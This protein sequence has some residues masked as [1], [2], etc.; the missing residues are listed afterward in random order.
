[1]NTLENRCPDCLYLELEGKAVGNQGLLSSLPQSLSLKKGKSNLPN[2]ID[3]HLTIN[4]NEQW[5]DMRVGRIKF[6]LSGG[7]LRLNLK[8]GEIPYN[9]RKLNSE[10]QLEI[11]KERQ[12]QASQ[13]SKQGTEGSLEANINPLR[14]VKVVMKGILERKASAGRTDKFQFTAAQ[15]TTKGLPDKP[16]WVFEDKT[17]ESVLLGSLIQAQLGTMEVTDKP[18]QVEA[19]FEVSLRDV[20]LTDAEG[21]WPPGVSDEKKAALDRGLVKLLLRHKFKP[22]LSRQVLHYD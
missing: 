9:L 20:K 16:V 8:N 19:R 1:M 17:G 10:L 15:V 3:L 13:E 14:L 21:L 5:Q 12:Q 18:C 2:Q 7:E 6:G 11:T 22:Y 4:F